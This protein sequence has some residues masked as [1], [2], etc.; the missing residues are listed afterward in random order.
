MEGKLAQTTPAHILMASPTIRKDLVERLWV[1]HIETTSYKK[2]TVLDANECSTPLANSREPAYLLPL[3]EIDVQVGGK[4]IEAGV[5][6]PGS[7][8]IVMREDLAR[9]VGATINA[10]HLLQMEGANRA[11][12]WTLG[13]AEYLPMCA[14]DVSFTVH[15]HVVEHAPFQLL[16]G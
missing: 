2:A 16:L 10:D 13:C 3:R 11:T 5:I 12:N 14:G 4:I 15:A 6:D 8:I 1:H 7:Q 9:E